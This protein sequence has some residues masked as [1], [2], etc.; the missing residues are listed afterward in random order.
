MRR[1]LSDYRT[2]LGIV[3]WGLFAGADYAS[4]DKRFTASLGL[5]AD[6]NDYSPRMARLWHQL[7]PRA[8]VGYR[9]GKGL[10]AE[11]KRAGF[12]TS[13]RPIRRSG[14]KDADAWVNKSLH[15]MRVGAVQRQAPDGGCATG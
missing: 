12:I 13:C 2:R 5:R 1:S 8:S 15:Y 11:R 4:E 7:S 3:G 14:F 9:L 6:G 10:V